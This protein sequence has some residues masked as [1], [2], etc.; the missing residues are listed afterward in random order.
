MK[1]R[2]RP[3]GCLL[4]VF[5][6]FFSG[7]AIAEAKDKK[8]KK[9]GRTKTVTNRLGMQFVLIHPGKFIMG[10]APRSECETCSAAADETP[11]HPVSITKPYYIGKYEVTQAQWLKLMKH[12]PSRFKGKNRPV[13][14]VSWN[15]VQLFILAL[16]RREK[17]D[18]YRLPT[19]AEWEFAAR[20]GTTTSYP[21]GDD[22]RKLGK[23]AWYSVNAGAKTHPVGKR[24][25]NTRGLYDMFGNVFEWC[26]D[27]YARDY[28]SKWV[29][30]D[31]KGP[32]EGSV[33]VRRGGFWGSHARFCR[34]S[35]R[36]WFSP[37]NR[38]S[39]IGFRLVKE[40]RK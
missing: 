8:G 24:K 40:Y 29:D 26:D 6:L 3:W 27:W 13:E 21:F 31:P 39:N 15:N 35:A 1:P 38:S 10:D 7:V 25:P 9:T 23:Y 22:P 19:E 37:D 32:R 12:N 14:Y 17:T 33:K 30:K 2:L 34:S 11:R 16:N 28:Y 20:G 5:F 4:L 36:S 18:S